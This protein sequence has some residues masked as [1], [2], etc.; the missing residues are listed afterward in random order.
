HSHEVQHLVLGVVDDQH[1][2]RIQANHFA[3]P[4][5]SATIAP[6]KPGGSVTSSASGNSSFPPWTL[7][8]WSAKCSP[9]PIPSGLRDMNGSIKN[10][11]GSLKPG[12]L[13]ATTMAG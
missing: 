10:S 2:R 12:P 3:P 5:T 4:K 8:T 11:G 7:I 6:S 9:R 1:L 13:S